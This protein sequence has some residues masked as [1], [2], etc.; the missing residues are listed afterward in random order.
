MKEKKKIIICAVVAVAIVVVGIIAGVFIGKRNADRNKDAHNSTSS[1]TTTTTTTEEESSTT[2]EISTS[3]STEKDVSVTVV[4]G[5]ISNTDR[6]NFADILGHILWF[7]F[8]AEDPPHSDDGYTA[9]E[10]ATYNLKSYDYKSSE[11]KR[12]AYSSLLTGYHTLAEEMSENYNWLDFELYEGA[13][14]YEIDETFEPD[15]KDLL[16]EIYCIIDEKYIDMSLKN[17]FNI[18][19]DHN[20]VLKSKDGEVYAYYYDGNYYYRGD[21]GGDGAGPDIV[22]SDIKVMND[23]KYS[24][25]ATYYVVGGDEREKIC[26]LNVIAEMKTFEGKS[27]WSFYTIEKV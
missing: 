6:N 22:I 2:N 17:V 27:I 8:D 3:E 7:N 10:Y 11:A 13:G 25:K 24:I 14:Y 5:I 21:E 23:G 12:Y 9:K 4:D 15:P 18:T 16:G 20:Y 1:T 19:P 26:D